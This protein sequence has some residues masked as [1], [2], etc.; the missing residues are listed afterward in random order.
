[1][2]IKDRIKE[3]RR[4]K[5]CELIPHVK[6]WRRHPEQQSNALRGVLAEVGWADAALVRETSDGLQLID[7]HLRTTVAHDAEIPVLILD[8]T[9]AEADLILATH[10]PLAAM[11]ETNEAALAELLSL[12]ESDNVALNQMLAD[13][14]PDEMPDFV[15]QHDQPRLDEKS[16]VTCPNCH[17]EFTP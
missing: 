2:Q 10:D 13:L 16:K 9:E 11:A 3:L 12:V 14:T 8:V 7:G 15:P 6:N 1:M 17:H 4:V 5:A